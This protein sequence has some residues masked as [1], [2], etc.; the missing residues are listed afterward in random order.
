[1]SIVQEIHIYTLK[2]F[3]L[4]EPRIAKETFWNL[5]GSGQT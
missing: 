3:S 1:M 5:K 4:K 2:V